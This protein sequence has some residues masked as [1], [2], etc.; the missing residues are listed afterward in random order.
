MER[1]C[2]L[3]AKSPSNED[4]IEVGKEIGLL[5]VSEAVAQPFANGTGVPFIGFMVKGGRAGGPDGRG[6]GVLIT[7]SS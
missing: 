6:L 7:V 3:A 2:R 4:C 5:L 1:P